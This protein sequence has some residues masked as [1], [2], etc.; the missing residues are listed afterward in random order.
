MFYSFIPGETQNPADS[1][2]LFTRKLRDSLGIS[3]NRFV[4]YKEIHDRLEKEK[5]PLPIIFVDDFVGSGSQCYKAWCENKGGA[6]SKTLGQISESCGHK[7]VYAPLIV[8]HQGYKLITQ[9]CNGL[10]LSPSHII[11]EEY[12]LFNPKCICWEGNPSLYHS[13]TEMILRKSQELGIPSTDGQH[14]NDERGFNKQGLALAFEHGA[15]DAIPAFFYW[16]CDGWTPLIQK[17][18]QR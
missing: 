1:G 16:C 13:G 2:N 7:I 3:E 9:Y 4:D 15:P 12:S 14:V 17:T 5:T 10:I 11:G 6:N 8:N 18:Y